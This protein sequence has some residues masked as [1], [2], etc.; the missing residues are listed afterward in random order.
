MDSSTNTDAESCSVIRSKRGCCGLS[1]RHWLKFISNLAIPFMIGV[2]TIVITIHQQNVA[3][4]NREKDGIQAAE[5]RRQDLEVARRRWEED[6]E[7]ARLQREEDKKAGHL[8][9]EEDKE[10]AR[11]Q[12]EEDRKAAADQRTEDK[13]AARLERELNFNIAKDKR[14][15]EYELAE[16]QRNLYQSQNAHE[17]E[18]IQQNYMND[19]MLEDNRQKENIIMNYQR[20]LS[21]LLIDNRTKFNDFDHTFLFVLQMK[22]RTVLQILDPTRRTIVVQTLSQAGLLRTTWK[23][24]NSL[25]YRAN[26]SGVHFGEPSD[27]HT[28]D[29]LIRYRYLNIE[30]GDV[31]YSSFRSVFFV[32]S[33][34]FAF[35]KLDYTDWSFSQLI[36]IVFEDKITMNNAVFAESQ[37]ITVTFDK[38]LMNYVSFQHNKY[39]RNCRFVKTSLLGV[40]LDHSNFSESVFSTLSMA[41]G[42]MSNGSFIYSSF[43]TVI[44]DRVDLSGA[45]FQGSTF[46]NVSMVNCTM[47]GVRL[48]ET[49]LTNVNLKGCKGFKYEQIYSMITFSNVILPNGTFFHS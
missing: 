34:V 20:E 12:R 45:D 42:N 14:M 13:E 6:K 23:R 17:A 49:K 10:I 28:S 47:Y 22:T 31:Q 26:L 9:R 44:L 33:P 15:Q 21:A 39:C 32:E 38:I 48:H 1:I 19:L 11:L 43:E 41:D 40:R 18:I 27:L 3:Q 5:L 16:K 29:V 35:S 46:R 8:Q 25:L 7:L 36:H 37:L 24:E 30:Q 2:F 4:M